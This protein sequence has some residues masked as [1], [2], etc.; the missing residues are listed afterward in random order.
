[1]ERTSNIEHRTSN[2][3]RSARLANSQ[4]P[5]A[6]TSPQT[7]IF[8]ESGD[9]HDADGNRRA[10]QTTTGQRVTK[11]SRPPEWSATSPLAPKPGDVIF[12]SQPQGRQ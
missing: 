9:I 5:T 7:P 11:T 6:F 1:M 3:E 12:C 4:K 8:Q 2:F 10:T